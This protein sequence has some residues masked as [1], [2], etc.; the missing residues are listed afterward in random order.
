MTPD[1]IK[2]LITILLRLSDNLD[3]AMG[4]T[5]GPQPTAEKL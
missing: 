2:Q 1:A 5:K 3:S 4:L